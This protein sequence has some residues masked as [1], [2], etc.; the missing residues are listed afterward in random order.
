MFL[1]NFSQVQNEK[2]VNLSLFFFFSN[3]HLRSHEVSAKNIF[4]RNEHLI[5]CSSEIYVE[6]N[7]IQIDIIKTTC[8]FQCFQKNILFISNPI[9]K[10]YPIIHI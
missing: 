4:E 10:G 7:C 6:S 5:F 3:L 8:F 1:L 9:Q 2:V